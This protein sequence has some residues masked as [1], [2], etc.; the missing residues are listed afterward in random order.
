MSRWSKW[1]MVPVL[2]VSLSAVA[3][4][5]ND[6]V[7]ERIKPV[8]QVCIEGED[9]GAAASATVGTTA[10]EPRSG[11][12]VYNGACTACHAS[13]AAGAPKLGDTGAWVDRI[14]QG[15]DTLY[16]NALTGLNA[17]PAKGLCMDCSDEEIKLAVDY[18]VDNSQ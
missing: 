4:T 17:M 16:E 2:A 9:C 15:N 6:S 14:A 1:M 13:G 18:M 12:L 11:E 7:A 8:G 10:G 3:S 5:Y